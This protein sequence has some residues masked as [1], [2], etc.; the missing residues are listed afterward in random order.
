ML[1]RIHKK[2]ILPLKWWINYQKRTRSIELRSV[3]AV[4]EKKT[5][6]MEEMH[7]HKRKNRKTEYEQAEGF[8]QALDWLCL[9]L[10]EYKQ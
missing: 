7:E 9:E 3:D 10:K 8:I 4:L 6:I 2:A 5:Q 1:R